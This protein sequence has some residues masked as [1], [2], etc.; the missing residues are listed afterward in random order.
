MNNYKKTM[1][2]FGLNSNLPEPQFERPVSQL[3]DGEYQFLLSE[4]KW[5][6][7]HPKK[8]EAAD[9]NIELIEPEI[10]INQDTEEED[11]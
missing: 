4:K 3:S 7:D 8:E 6:I 11:E 2:R 1:E 9:K 5:N 10:V